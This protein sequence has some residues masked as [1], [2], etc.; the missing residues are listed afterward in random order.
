MGFVSTWTE[1]LK[2]FNIQ[3]KLKMLLGECDM[4][5]SFHFFKMWL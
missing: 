2:I 1:Q 4:D 5:I 3:S